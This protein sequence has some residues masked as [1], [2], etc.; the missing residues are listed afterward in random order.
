MGGSFMDM[1][2]VEG[3]TKIY[4]NKK[5]IFDVTFEVS[6][7]EV[8]GFIGPNGAGKST[9][10]RTLLG[11]LHPNSGQFTLMGKP[12][13]ASLFHQIGYLP[14]EVAY[15]PTMSV[16]AFLLY[17]ATFF[18]IG[19][20]RMYE[21]MTLFELEGHL[22]VRDLSL[23]N[24]KK[25]GLVQTFMHEPKLVILDEPTSGL[26][27]LMQQKFYQLILDEKAKGTTIMISS[28]VLSEV[29]RLC[30]RVAIIKNGRILKVDTV[31]SIR[32]TNVK[33]VVLKT[34][35]S[36][37]IPIEIKDLDIQDGVYRFM[38]SG[39]IN[40]L[41]QYLATIALDEVSIQEPELEEIFMH[42]YE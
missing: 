29:Q 14:G 8:F 22:K 30:D 4:P 19:T 36:L 24:K 17:N 15:Y 21:L 41:I 40:P 3:L 20:K 12:F 28:H 1:I 34:N 6:E 23:G 42:Y 7:G 27:P 35:E 10:I 13:D 39:N 9:T 32:Q 37:Q 18:K 11:L 25:L 5:G 31:Q 26:D 16:E 33:R 2:K 38:Y